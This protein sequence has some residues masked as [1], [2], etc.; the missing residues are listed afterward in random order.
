M[1]NLVI[2]AANVLAG[3]DA[4]KETGTA[5][6]TITAGQV[7]ARASTGLYMLADANSATA[8]IRQP[9]GIALNGAANG[10]PLVIQR[11]GSI[12]IG[13][14]LTAGTDYY[15]SDTP[16]AIAPRADIGSGEYVASLGYATSTTVL[17]LNIQYT[18]VAL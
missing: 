3:S 5:G 17:G 9:R 6:E 15:L 14:A 7:V 2:T 11:S 12:T 8:A 10:Q 4:S 1:A 16:G 13:A 18:G